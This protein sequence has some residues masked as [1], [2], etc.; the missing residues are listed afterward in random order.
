MGFDYSNI[1]DI[2]LNQINDKGRIICIVYKT[3]GSYDPS[4]D[5]LFADTEKSVEVK[6]V[7]TN[8]KKR[9]L[10][11]SLIEKGDLQV[12][13]AASGIKKPKVDDTIID[14]GEFNIIDVEEVKPG[15]TPLIYKLQVRR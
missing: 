4:D 5:T 15:D 8:Y 6:A 11:E 3:E 7:I 12:I 13:I 2:A 9:D 14:D 1:A 10:V